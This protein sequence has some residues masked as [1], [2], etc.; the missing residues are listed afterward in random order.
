M[1]IGHYY[2]LKL[3]KILQLGRQVSRV[4]DFLNRLHSFLRDIYEAFFEE[5]AS[6]D[7]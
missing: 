2:G 1:L 7:K 6:E 4:V 5:R 3:Q